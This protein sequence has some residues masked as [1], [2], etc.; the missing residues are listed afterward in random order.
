[1]PHELTR[2]IDADG[3]HYEATVLIGPA[4]SASDQA[5]IGAVIA[6]LRFPRLYTGERVGNE[7][8]LGGYRSACHLRFDQ[9]DQQFYCT[10]SPARGTG[11]AERSAHGPGLGAPME[12]QFAFAKVAWGG[13]VVSAQAWWQPAAY[14]G[15]RRAVA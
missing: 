9:R 15:A 7:T 8:V 12:L 3:Q 14:K 6:S 13:H 1:M 5:A 11:P 10:N 4:A 2:P